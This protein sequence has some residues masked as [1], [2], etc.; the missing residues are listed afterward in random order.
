MEGSPVQETFR[1]GCWFYDPFIK[2][3]IEMP[4][5]IIL[6]DDTVQMA[7]C[8][9]SRALRVAQWRICL[10][11]ALEKPNT[12]VAD[13]ATIGETI[14]VC[15]DLIT[16]ED[17][18]S[19]KNTTKIIP[20]F[21]DVITF[22]RATILCVQSKFTANLLAVI[23]NESNPP[24]RCWPLCTADVLT[25]EQHKSRLCKIQACSLR[26]PPDTMRD[27]KESIEIRCEVEFYPEKKKPYTPEYVFRELRLND[28]VPFAMCRSLLQEVDCAIQVHPNAVAS[29][30]RNWPFM[31]LRC[32]RPLRPT[33]IL[34][35]VCLGENDSH[36]IEWLTNGT[37]RVTLEQYHVD[38]DKI[39]ENLQHILMQT[40][41]NAFNVLIE[42]KTIIFSETNEV[43]ESKFTDVRINYFAF[44][45]VP[46][47]RRLVDDDIRESLFRSSEQGDGALK[48]VSLFY[49]PDDERV[50]ISELVQ[51]N[52]IRNSINGIACRAFLRG[53][54]V[55]FLLV[56]HAIVAMRFMVVKTLPNEFKQSHSRLGIDK[57][58]PELAS[59]VRNSAMSR[60]TWSC[61]EQATGCHRI[62]SVVALNPQSDRDMERYNKAVESG[63]LLKFRGF[64][65]GAC[66]DENN[67][68]DKIRQLRDAPSTTIKNKSNNGKKK[69]AAKLIFFGLPVLKSIDD[70]KYRTPGYE[71]EDFRYFPACIRFQP[72]MKMP[73]RY[74]ASMAP[75]YQKEIIDYIGHDA[76]NIVSQLK[77]FTE[78]SNIGPKYVMK[79]NK[80]LGPGEY[81]ELP[82]GS[83]KDYMNKEDV[84]FLRRG[85]F[86]DQDGRFAVLHALFDACNVG[87]YREIN[88]SVE[89]QDF[90]RQKAKTM[91]EYLRIPIDWMCSSTLNVCRSKFVTD[92]SIANT[93]FCDLFSLFHNINVVI[94]Q[95][96]YA[97]PDDVEISFAGNRYVDRWPN[98]LIIRS[99][100]SE[101][102]PIVFE[103]GDSLWEPETIFI[104]KLFEAFFP[105]EYQFN[106]RIHDIIQCTGVS[107]LTQILLRTQT[108]VKIVAV[109]LPNGISIPVIQ[110]LP[111]V[112]IASHILVSDSC[113]HLDPVNFLPQ[114]MEISI[115]CPAFAPVSALLGID[116]LVHAIILADKR[117]ICHLETPV[118]RDILS[119]FKDIIIEFNTSFVGIPSSVDYKRCDIGIALGPD[120]ENVIHSFRRLLECV[121][122]RTKV[123]DWKG[124][125]H[126]LDCR[127]RLVFFFVKIFLLTGRFFFRKRKI[128]Q[129]FVEPILVNNGSIPIARHIMCAILVSF[130]DFHPDPET[131]INDAFFP[132]QNTIVGKPSDTISANETSIKFASPKEYLN[133]IARRTE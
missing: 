56:M 12:S 19:E 116:N 7:K 81:G 82:A 44:A 9:I 74:L 69:Y 61:K 52:I 34:F 102:E 78:K 97:R 92:T 43:T 124:L 101:F 23:G 123:F 21:L 73:Q 127:A 131:W 10:F 38:A 115:R 113:F 55:S 122:A 3:F 67:N 83:V 58:D 76:E 45:S 71:G 126:P 37:F 106:Q 86:K 107:S 90:V 27:I 28:K 41:R 16:L 96:S 40:C 70:Q 6:A 8:T 129:L 63:P 32:S 2:K 35:R 36:L 79:A 94:F 130:C 88:G 49:E 47:I 128:Q 64:F 30:K 29:C 54:S 104:A 33:G 117:L 42:S 68:G 50:N 125:L 93:A 112:W 18:I 111:V 109:R 119:Q 14:A 133:W 48:N 84:R 80:M 53:R 22:E 1:V 72:G 75:L 20:N 31:N 99:G 105:N 62:R 51:C 59:S 118:S 114:L 17:A 108:G 4:Q 121:Y 65:Y 11:Y 89:R 98:V 66:D 13:I 57:I 24:S 132:L 91:V 100:P 77:S 85:V 39:P 103:G 26:S 46:D 87:G 110:S 60:K 120:T 25:E 5:T 95:Y 15:D